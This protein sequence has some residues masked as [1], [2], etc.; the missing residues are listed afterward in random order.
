M[1]KPDLLTHT[2]IEGMRRFVGRFPTT[3]AAAEAED[4]VALWVLTDKESECVRCL[5]DMDS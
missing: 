3:A 2:S 4:F 1:L 5:D